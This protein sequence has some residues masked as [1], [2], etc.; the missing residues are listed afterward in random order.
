MPA[1]ELTSRLKRNGALCSGRIGIHAIYR[2]HYV[3][4]HQRQSYVITTITH[5][6]DGIPDFELEKIEQD[7]APA[8]SPR[9]LQE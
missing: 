6:P 9:W 3:D 7:L 8:L 1:S 4:E 2:A 5:H